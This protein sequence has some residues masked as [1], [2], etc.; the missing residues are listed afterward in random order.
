MQEMFYGCYSLENLD[1]LTGWN[2]CSLKRI[3]DM[4]FLCTA[5]KDASAM[6]G[7]FPFTHALN[8]S[9]LWDDA[10]FPPKCRAPKWVC[11]TKPTYTPIPAP[12]NDHL[13]PKMADH[14]GAAEE[15]HEAQGIQEQ[16]VQDGNVPDE[17]NCASKPLPA[18]SAMGFRLK[19]GLLKQ[20]ERAIEPADKENPIFPSKD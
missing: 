15:H 8:D 10:M 12:I 2:L 16:S 1:A 9:D 19:T 18:S 6:D 14:S 13:G 7:W 20:R 4:F 3:K 5:L 17:P 11:K